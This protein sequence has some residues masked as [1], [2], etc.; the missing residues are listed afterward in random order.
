VP[1]AFRASGVFTATVGTSIPV[2]VPGSVQD[3]DMMVV[4][5]TTQSDAATVTAPGGWTAFT[6]SPVTDAPTGDSRLYC[7]WRVASS[8]PV[9]YTF[10]LS[11]ATACSGGLVAYSSAGAIDQQ[12]MAGNS[13]AARTAV[14]PDITPG[15]TNTRVVC[16]FA[17]DLAGSDE[18]TVVGPLTKRIDISDS[19]AFTRIAFADSLASDLAQLYPDDAL[20]PSDI[21]YPLDGT[22]TNLHGTAHLA[23]SV[24]TMTAIASI[25]EATPVVTPSYRRTLLGVGA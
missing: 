23:S 15:A 22:E 21:L 5:I 6:E 20:Y 10:T 4:G 24:P 16:V 13:T 11:S 12:E 19:T 18:W 2:P 25:L 7:W 14:T 17:S 3:D 9:S 1:P 8:E